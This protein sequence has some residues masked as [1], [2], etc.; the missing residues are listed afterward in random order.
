MLNGGALNNKAFYNLIIANPA[1]A[2]NKS[3]IETVNANY[4]SA[5]SIVYS[6]SAYGFKATTLFD[7][8]SLITATGT[9]TGRVSVYGVNK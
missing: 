7:G 6:S 4:D 3:G 1:L 5:S 9:M 2:L 8:F